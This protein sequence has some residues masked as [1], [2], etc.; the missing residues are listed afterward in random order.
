M[1]NWLQAAKACHLV[2]DPAP[3]RLCGQAAWAADAQGHAHPCCVGAAARG[4]THCAGCRADLTLPPDLF[5]PPA[6]PERGADFGL[7]AS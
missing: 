3:C 6:L 2:A 7:E 4:E 5:E 1:T